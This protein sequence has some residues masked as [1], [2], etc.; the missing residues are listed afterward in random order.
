MEHTTISPP[1]CAEHGC[2]KVWRKDSSKKCGGRW[3]CKEC[4]NAAR[5]ARYRA[6]P[7]KE[8]ARSLAN[9][10]AN[11]EKA[12]EERRTRYYANLE[13][14]KK[15]RRIWRLANPEMVR[16][17][18]CGWRKA[19]PDKAAAV[20]HRRRA[21]KLAA[22][23][24]LA[25]VTAAIEAERF[26]LTDGCAYCGVDARKTV[27]HVVPFNLGGMHVPSNIVGACLSCNCSKSDRPVE[28]WF[29]AQPFFSEQRWQRIQ[30]ITGNGQ[31]SLI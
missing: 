1:I 17:I 2:E 29:K 22:T 23:S 30:Q 12:C 26:A 3:R 15:T 4:H 8:K 27:E 7:E 25:V 21:R 19:N 28:E 5:R 16:A 18:H 20:S 13:P 11:P 10:H 9:Y 24:P 31:L 14:E 6:N